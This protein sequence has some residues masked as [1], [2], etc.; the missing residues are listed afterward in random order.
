M[1]APHRHAPLP[2][3]GRGA[4]VGRVDT[5]TAWRFDDP[6][7]AEAALARL[8]TLA[9]QGLITVDDAAIVSWPTTRRRPQTRD[10]GSLTGPGA[11]WG[12]FWGMLLGLIFVV[13]LAGL[14][15]GAAAGA[16][17]GSLA[18]VGIDTA[19]IERVRERVTPGTSALFLLSHGAV[20]E[21]VAAE[22]A[23]LEMELIRSNLSADQERRL[24][25]ALGEEPSQPAA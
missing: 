25:E 12:G 15:L 11:L 16:L 5:L 23:G 18:D 19:F 20:V 1:P 24:R 22:M 8:R 14:A 13:P 4:S 9:E 10:L 7:G 17:A 6:G 3:T 21:R 2:R